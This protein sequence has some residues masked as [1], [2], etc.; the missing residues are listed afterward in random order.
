MS[1]STLGIVK[2]VVTTGSP[3]DNF[4]FRRGEF[5]ERVASVWMAVLVVLT[6]EEAE[7]E[8]VS[9]VAGGLS[10]QDLAGLDIA[11]SVVAVKGRTR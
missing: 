8:L 6:E 5:S 7:M 9:E 10:P 2:L 11:G 1:G 3:H 4:C